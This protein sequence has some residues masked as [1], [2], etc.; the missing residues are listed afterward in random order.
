MKKI[1]LAIACVSL[2]VTACGNHSESGTNKTAVKTDS[3][4][5]QKEPA[6][7][8]TMGKECGS[9]DK[10]GKCPSCGNEMVATHH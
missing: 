5:G 3:I 9:G 7:V 10:P 4:N 6:Y 1:I 2:M 8:C